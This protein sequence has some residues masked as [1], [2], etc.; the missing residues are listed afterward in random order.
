MYG[1]V[2]QALD[3]VTK[4]HVALK[5]CIPHHESS[6]G[7]P[8]TTLR[9]IHTLKVCCQH[10]NIVDLLEIAVSDKA[11]G[12][13]ESRAARGGVFLV[14][15]Y[16]P[17]D[18][19][20]IL[21]TYAAKYPSHRSR[22]PFHQSHVKA[23]TQQLLSAVDWCHQHFLIHRDIKPSNLLYSANGTLKLCDFGLSRHCSGNKDQP[24]L[25]ANVVSLWYRAPEL[26][27]PPAQPAAAEGV[28]TN[29][30]FSID[31]FSVG[32]IFCELLQGTPL[33]DGKTELEQIDKMVQCLGP[34]PSRLYRYDPPRRHRPGHTSALALWDRFDYL[35]TEGL[36]L[37][38]RLLEYD[39]SDRWTAGQALQ[40]RYF[41]EDPLPAKVMPSLREL[42]VE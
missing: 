36:S 24:P 40:S 6:D 41:S 10:P 37:A 11:G 5:R 14:F 22:S 42:R 26:L 19:A 20:N 31:L 17:S 13:E 16:C 28:L 25:T 39:P 27:F 23:L 9:E 30:S 3:K 8:L 33:L 1:V 32:C 4:Q 34:P 18:L 35:S 2:Y 38:T 12:K 21:D 7:F 15:E 29:Y